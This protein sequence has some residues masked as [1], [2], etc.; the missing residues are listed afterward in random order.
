MRKLEKLHR[1]SAVGI[2]LAAGLFIAGCQ[3][4]VESKPWEG[5]W[6]VSSWTTPDGDVQ[7]SKG[8]YHYYPDGKFASQVMIPERLDLDADPETLEELADAFS[9]YRA[10][11]GTY[12][13]DEQ[14]GKLTYSYD[15]NMRTHRVKDEP[16]TVAFEI[17]DEDMVFT[18]E[19]GG[20]LVFLR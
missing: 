11:Y 18:Y 13:V 5:R 19:S 10:G 4:K 14:A 6:I 2:V 17:T 12:S 3:Q 7:P 15:S 16:T 8:L 1:V 9:T 20:K